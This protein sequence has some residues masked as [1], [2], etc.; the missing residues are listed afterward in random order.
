MKAALSRKNLWE[1]TP[2]LIKSTLGAV[3][4]KVSPAWW[5]GRSFRANCRFVQD[6]QWWSAQIA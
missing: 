2:A 6:A 4:G 3:M 5:L 1:K